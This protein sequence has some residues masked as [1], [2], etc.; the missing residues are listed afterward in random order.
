MKATKQPNTI[1]NFFIQLLYIKY[2]KKT[3]S[4]DLPFVLIDKYGEILYNIISKKNKEF[5]MEENFNNVEPQEVQEEIQEET[6]KEGHSKMSLI[7]MI[8]PIASLCLIAILAI[9]AGFTPIYVGVFFG[10]MNLIILGLPIAG[11]IVAYIDKK[12]FKTIEFLLNVATIMVALI[13][14]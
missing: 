8:L 4:F 5:T 1:K 12:D 14:F 9:V 3:T 11:G 13:V 6:K 7:S 2:F 10:I